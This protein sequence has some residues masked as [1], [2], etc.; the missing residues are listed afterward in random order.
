MKFH[1]LTLFPEMVMQ[2]IMTSV[3]GRAVR[4]HMIEADAVDIRDYTLDK[5]RKVD[6]YPY[7]GGAGMLMQAQPVYDACQDVFFK[8][9]SEHRRRVVYVTPQG[10]PFNQKIAEE[11]SQNDDLVIL[12]GHYEG[13][14]ER[15]LEEVVTDYVSIGDYVLTGGELAAMVIVDAVA[16]LV[17]GVLHNA[18]SSETESFHSNLLEH[19]QYS[20]PEKWHGKRVPD[21]LLSGDAKRIRTW[22][23]EES[24]RRTKERRPDLYE[25]YLELLE[26]R[27]QLEKQKRLHADM[28][29][30]IDRGSAE[31]VIREKNHILLR[32]RNSGIIFHTSL[33]KGGE[34]EFWEQL[35]QEL[36]HSFSCAVLHQELSKEPF[37]RRTNMRISDVCHN[38]IYTKKEKLPFRGLYR[39]EEEA[40]ES[41][42][43]RG[44]DERGKYGAY[45]HENR[46]GVAGISATGEIVVYELVSGY[47]ELPV[48]KALWTF[49]INL[50]LEQGLI[51]YMQISE[52]D[53]ASLALL[54]EMGLYVSQIPV[55]WMSLEG[56]TII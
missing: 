50:V 52:D 35:P 15:V 9:P 18:E 29:T 5:H 37:M 10:I 56:D 43:I 27:M 12:C 2:G 48:K 14:D 22:Q 13:I 3:T 16:R 25:R 21:V 55:F 46:I 11:F 41:L 39:P 47:E 33:S 1:I 32:D 8:I 54:E 45:F 51:P 20:R 36:F 38:V 26:C 23:L 53:T 19:P 44:Q 49:L 4:E 6:D 31:L 17:P 40:Q 30:L 34:K 24:I 28:L 42:Y 7:G